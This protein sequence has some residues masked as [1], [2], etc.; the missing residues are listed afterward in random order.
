MAHKQTRAWRWAMGLFGLSLVCAASVRS[1]S[2]I[3]V[4]KL[5]RDS[6]LAT[7]GRM[8]FA[9]ADSGR[10]LLGGSGS[11]SDW[12]VVANRP[13]QGRIRGLAYGRGVLFLSDDQGAVYRLNRG[14]QVA[15]VL[16]KGPPL[17]QPGDLAFSGGLLVADTGANA[18][19]R[20]DVDTRRV[21][22]FAT[23]LPA[24]RLHLAA[25]RDAVAIVSPE[26][27][28]IREPA[29]FEH[30]SVV[31]K[32]P[33][34]LNLSVWRTK[35]P[36]PGPSASGGSPQRRFPLLQKPGAVTIARGNVYV[37]DEEVG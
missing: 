30:G 21:Q 17:V 16:A 26:A 27:A 36:A 11:A 19:F 29:P 6:P 9:V 23:G 12:K 37:V 15:V 3:E 13:T 1:Q 8:V 22:A 20:V 2:R 25:Q 24:G 32:A 33:E 5:A 18:V 7:D 31:Q 10:M 14:E 4:S 28:E 34:A 35:F